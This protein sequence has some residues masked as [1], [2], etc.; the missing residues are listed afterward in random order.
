MVYGASSAVGA[1]A[2]KFASAADI[3]P[4][5]AIGSR[6]SAFVEEFLDSAKG[7]VLIDYKAHNSTQ[8]ILDAVQNALKKAG[9]ADGRPFHAFDTV[10]QP[11]TFDA[12]LA[13]AMIGPPK[14]GRKPKIAT[15]LPEVDYSIVDPSVDVEMVYC[16]LAHEGDE[17]AI[18]FAAALF[19]M[20]TPAL[21]YG[22]MKGHPYEVT[23]GGL[24]G[25]GAALKASKDGEIR[26]KKL[27]LRIAESS[28][29]Q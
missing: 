11:E 9:I 16:G 29:L 24:D 14:D 27:V 19:R 10:S 2:I 15:V 3:H 8:A 28:G 6:S 1:F 5:V 20:M 18:R 12:V 4:I 23:P 26:A 25:V 22:W 13:K 7:D 17:H 21:E